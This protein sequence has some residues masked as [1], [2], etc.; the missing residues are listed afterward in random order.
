M[1]ATAVGTLLG[2]IGLF[3]LGM[4]HLTEGLKGLAGDS[5]ATLQDGSFPKQMSGGSAAATGRTLARKTP[6]AALHL[7]IRL[8][9]EL[10]ARAFRSC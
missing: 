9:H 8:L 2:G 6:I 4:H 7:I 3:R 5:S 1:D 10:S